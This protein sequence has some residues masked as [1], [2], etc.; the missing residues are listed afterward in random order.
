M[1]MWPPP[2]PPSSSAPPVSPAPSAHW[3]S[4]AERSAQENT[5][6]FQ[7]HREPGAPGIQG[8]QGPRSSGSI[9][10][11]EGWCLC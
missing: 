11:T 5:A 2:A 7:I 10:H 6:G 8:F 9:S 3:S 1:K 4:G